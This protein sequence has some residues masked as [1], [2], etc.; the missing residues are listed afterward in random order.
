M[1]LHIVESGHGD[2]ATQHI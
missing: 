1:T 2:R